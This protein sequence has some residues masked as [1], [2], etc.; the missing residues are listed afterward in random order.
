LI[1]LTSFQKL[2]QPEVFDWYYGYFRN[3]G[4]GW[5]RKRVLRI[6][7]KMNLKLRR[8]RKKRL[9]TRPKQPLIEAKALN[10]TWSMDFV[11]DALSNGRRVRVLNIIDD[12]TREV[13]A[14]HADYSICSQ[15]VIEVLEHLKL[16]R[17]LP[18]S[19]RTDNGPEFISKKLAKWCDKEQI[20]QKF[21]QPGK[22]MQNGFNERLN[23]T[24]REDV[25]NAYFFDSLEQ[26]RILSDKW[27]Y[28]Y[29]NNHPHRSLNRMT[30]NQK[31]LIF[32]S[33]LK[34]EK[35]I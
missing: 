6:Y 30:P 10:D 4:L 1:S 7:R 12:S 16:E 28:D 19:I 24:Y 9:L 18:K 20:E 3:E 15:K 35:G 31:R 22:P 2:T 11:S 17:G 5:N 21:I 13:L 33:E 8:R 25:L 14:A 23:R 27:M 34:G 32:E 26:L 29:N